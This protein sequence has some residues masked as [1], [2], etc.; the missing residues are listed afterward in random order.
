MQEVAV[1]L[2]ITLEAVVADIMVV[3]VVLLQFQ[4]VQVMAALVVADHLILE[5]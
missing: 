1:L 5:V 2:P 3:L 4:L